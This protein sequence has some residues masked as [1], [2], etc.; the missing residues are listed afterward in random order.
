LP[1]RDRA[2]LETAYATGM[3]LGE[4]TR[5]L[6][7]DI[8]SQRMAIRVDQGKGRKDRYVMLSQSLLETLRAY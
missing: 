4:V 1:L 3:R 5:L 2:L 8:D 6:L 7:R